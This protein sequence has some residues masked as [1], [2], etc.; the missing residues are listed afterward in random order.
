M[1]T[2]AVLKSYLL[3][4]PSGH[5]FDL[6]CELFAGMFPPDETNADARAKLDALAAECNCKV[7]KQQSRRPVRTDAAMSELSAAGRA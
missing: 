4:M 7:I 2:E 1:L 5:I 3:E 6:T